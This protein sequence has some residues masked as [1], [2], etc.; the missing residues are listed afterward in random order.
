M[1][2]ACLKCASYLSDMLQRTYTETPQNKTTSMRKSHGARNGERSVLATTLVSVER[3]HPMLEN[4][5]RM[6][7]FTEAGAGLSKLRA[8]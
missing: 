3:D 2:E 1:I 5:D 7:C 8:S 6:A 4:I